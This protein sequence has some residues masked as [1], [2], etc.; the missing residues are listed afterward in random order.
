MWDFW[1]SDYTPL[2]RTLA[3]NTSNMYDTVA[4][5]VDH[6]HLRAEAG[7]WS[8]GK[9]RGT[10]VDTVT[11]AKISLQVLHFYPVGIMPPMLHTHISFI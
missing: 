8:Q 1:K 7:V 4:Q 11:P 3:L 9:L 10:T 6:W 5:V 2:D